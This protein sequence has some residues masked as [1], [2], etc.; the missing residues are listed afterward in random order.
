LVSVQIIRQLRPDRE[1]TSPGHRSTRRIVNPERVG[2]CHRGNVRTPAAGVRVVEELVETS[3]VE[4]ENTNHT[5]GHR[6]LKS[7]QVTSLGQDRAIDVQAVMNV[8]RGGQ[9]NFTDEGQRK[10]SARPEIE[11]LGSV[12]RNYKIAHLRTPL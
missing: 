3:A 6:E 7:V 8:D 1:R 10:R 11:R 5:R 2:N 12:I 4:L 9:L